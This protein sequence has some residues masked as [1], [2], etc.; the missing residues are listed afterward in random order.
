MK[1]TNPFGE[2]V[3]DIDSTPGRYGDFSKLMI[4]IVTDRSDHR[5]ETL[6]TFT[7]PDGLEVGRFSDVDQ[8][9]R[10][11]RHKQASQ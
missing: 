10:L 2:P 4:L 9:L 3:T 1:I 5:G 7:T 8:Q 11:E 6:R